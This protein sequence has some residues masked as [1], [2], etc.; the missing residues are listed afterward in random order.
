MDYLL[1]QQFPESGKFTLKIHIALS[2]EIDRRIGHA[3]AGETDDDACDTY[4]PNRRHTREQSVITPGMRERKVDYLSAVDARTSNFF[5]QWFQGGSPREVRWAAPALMRDYASRSS[6]A[7]WSECLL[8]EHS[9][10]WEE[11]SDEEVFQRIFKTI[12]N[13]IWEDN[14]LAYRIATHLYKFEQY[15][16]PQARHRILVVGLRDDLNINF[17]VPDPARYGDYDVSARN[18]IENPPIREGAPNHELPCHSQEVVER[19]SHI[20]PGQ[21]VSNASSFS[22]RN[23]ARRETHSHRAYRRLA[24]DKPAYTV[25]ASGGGGTHLHHWNE[26]RALTNRELARLQCFPDKFIFMGSKG[27]IRKQVGNAVPPA[28]ATIIG[29]ELLHSLSLSG[30]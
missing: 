6:R 29:V 18:A 9:G 26:N 5:R 7:R 10:R 17:E 21:N 1:G 30:D 2:K 20:L 13:P 12:Q 4:L 3:P 14:N 24:S 23:F 19:L 16:V 22:K 15:G 11:S 27:E 28:A 25:T 8:T